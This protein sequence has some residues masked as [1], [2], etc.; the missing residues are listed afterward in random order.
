MRSNDEV[1]EILLELYEESFAGKRR[2]RFLLSKEDIRQMYPISR[3][4]ESRFEDLRLAAEEVGLYIF[5]AGRNDIDEVFGVVKSQTVDRW[6]RLPR[7]I[8]RRF[9][10]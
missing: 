9:V 1:A 5:K 3:I 2:Q 7:K 6:R 8:A 4:E 10:A